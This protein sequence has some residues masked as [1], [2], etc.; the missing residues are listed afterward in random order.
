MPVNRSSL[1]LVG[2]RG[3]ALADTS[4]LADRG[5]LR[6]RSLATAGTAR[7]AQAK[8]LSAFLSEPT[9]VPRLLAPW[10]P[11]V[12]SLRQQ[13]ALLRGQASRDRILKSI[14]GGA[15]AVGG[16]ATR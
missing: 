16:P 6:R 5:W 4:G 15:G 9:P 11:A 3:E 2:R 7:Q 8:F 1:H 14:Q 13:V 12:A 10:L